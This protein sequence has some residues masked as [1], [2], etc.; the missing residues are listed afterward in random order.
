MKLADK[1]YSLGTETA[2]DVLA[3]VVKLQE[4]GKNII[5]FAIGEPDFDSPENIK[6]AGIEAIKNNHTHYN[7]SAGLLEVRKALA[8]YIERTRGIEVSPLEV[9]ITPGAKPI[10]FYGLLATINPGDEVIYPNPGFPIYE[11]MINYVGGVAVPLA[12]REEKEFSFRPEELETKINAKT[13][14][15][16]LNSPHNPT[17]GML[18]TEDLQQIARIA[19]ENDLW[20]M[21]DEVYSRIIYDQAFESI[22]SIPGM[23]ER[24]ILIEGMSKTYAMTGW[25]IGYGVAPEIVVNAIARLCTNS[26]SCTATFTQLAA[27][28]AVTGPQEDTTKMVQEFKERKDLIVK[29]LNEIEGIS[30]LNPKGAFYV[31][32][33][34]TKACQNKGFKNAKELQEFLL[35]ESGVA[36]LPQT[37]FGMRNEGETEEY[38]RLSFATSKENIIEGLKRIKKG[39]ERNE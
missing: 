39:L 3:E 15:I 1:M 37:S 16:I 20:V 11:S 26:I 21:A 30:C 18:S 19:I 9:V 32:P 5:S 2:F 31:Y 7:P 6:Q 22:I 13:K 38:I 35:H 24:T 8:K 12:L 14:M 25:R 28:E 4:Q 29:G 27:L 23:K 10:I 33:N 17:G 34:V 36:V